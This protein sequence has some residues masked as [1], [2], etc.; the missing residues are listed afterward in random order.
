MMQYIDGKFVEVVEFDTMPNLPITG[1]TEDEQRGEQYKVAFA[2]LG[3]REY[4]PRTTGDYA[5]AL[6]DAIRTGVITKPGKYG[7]HIIPANVGNDMRYEIYEIKE[8]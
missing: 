7:I 1:L 2:H 6:T 3:G 5:N 8:D 4:E